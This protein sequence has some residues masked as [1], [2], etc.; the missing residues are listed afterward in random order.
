M[1]NHKEKLLSIFLHYI[2]EYVTQQGKQYI[3]TLAPSFLLALNIH[4]SPNEKYQNQNYFYIWNIQ[5]M[6][7]QI[8]N[9]LQIKQIIRL[10]KPNDFVA[11]LKRIKH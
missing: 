4:S 7:W 11:R 1:Q 10:W 3:A 6:D 5:T 8:C 2:V 9:P